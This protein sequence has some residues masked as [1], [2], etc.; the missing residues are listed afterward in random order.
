MVFISATATICESGLP[1]DHLRERFADGLVVFAA[2][3]D[4]DTFRIIREIGYLRV[5][6]HGVVVVHIP[7][8]GSDFEGEI[9]DVHAVTFGILQ[10]EAE[11]V[12]ILGKRNFFVLVGRAGDDECVERVP[13][14]FKFVGLRRVG[15]AERAHLD[16]LD[17]RRAGRQRGPLV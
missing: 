2:R 10:D 17:G 12:R 11:F 1:G 4:V 6:E 14:G 15:V 13:E 3:G 16:V 9:L 7:V 5:V 8:V